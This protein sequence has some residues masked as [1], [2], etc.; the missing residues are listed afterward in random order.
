MAEHEGEFEFDED[1][2]NTKDDAVA[3]QNE[4]RSLPTTTSAKLTRCIHCFR[5][6]VTG[7][8]ENM[9]S[10]MM[11]KKDERSPAN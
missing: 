8:V 11:F 7:M 6:S 1:N 4:L 5:I 2:E 10:M 3:S 9:K